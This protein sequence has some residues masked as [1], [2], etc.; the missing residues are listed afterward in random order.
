M[1]YDVTA[2]GAF[3]LL[4]SNHAQEL[5]TLQEEFKA[6]VS[7]AEKRAEEAMDSTEE[8]RE[9][10]ADE[11][12][13]RFVEAFR[14]AGINVPEE[15]NLFYTGSEDERPGRTDA[16]AEEWVLG[17]GMLTMPWDWPEMD[18]SFRKAAFWHTWV[19]GG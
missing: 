11:W 13:D 19:V 10:V 15:A 12:V 5:S 1:G 4:L 18:A 16:P 2:Q 8:A 6:A 9:V 3:G 17:F 7:E 14:Q